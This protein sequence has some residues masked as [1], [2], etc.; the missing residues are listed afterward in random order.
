VRPDEIRGPLRR[1][2]LRY[3]LATSANRAAINGELT[4][5]N[6]GTAEILMELETDDDLRARFEMEL[7]NRSEPDR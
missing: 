1:D 4:H 7:L 3:L 2:L 6:P 5:R